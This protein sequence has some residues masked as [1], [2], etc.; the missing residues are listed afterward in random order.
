MSSPGGFLQVFDLVLTTQAPLFIGNGKTIL[1]KMYLYDKRTHQV[2]IFDEEKLFALL[3]EKD[4]IEP[5]ETFMLG[6]LDNLFVFLTQDCHL[7]ES[8][9]KVAV[10][11][12][13]DAGAALDERHTLTD[14]QSFIRDA[15]GRVYV[16]G[17]SVKGALRTVLLHQMILEEGEEHTQLESD[18]RI[19]CGVIPEGKYLHT[20][21]L[22]QNRQDD[23]VNSILRGMQV[24]DS[25][26]V[27]DESMVLADKWDYQTNGD[28]KKVPV[29]RESIRPGTPIYLKLTLDQSILKGRITKERL[30]QAI[31][32][33][34]QYYRDTYL[35]KFS[36][37]KNE[38]EFDCK[39]CL[40]LG[41]GSGF[42]AKSLIYPYLGKERG[43]QKTAEIMQ[44]SF[45]NHHHDRDEALGI[46]PHTLKYTLYQGKYYPMGMC[47]V[48][49]R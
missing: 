42:F 21:K 25:L 35:Q 15:A 17:S 18:R 4:L 14:V 28:L 29:C 36:Q 9:W 37:P 20:L 48:E 3:L 22:K 27:P 41:G 2:S 19:K 47:G 44:Y 40:F 49:I 10:R 8:Q 7:T 34:N 23:M 38:A 6:R 45:R 43:L 12:S 30:M 13:F 24:S 31:D 1:K 16:P 11:Y 32:D 5:F 39:G 26:P 33:F 46:S